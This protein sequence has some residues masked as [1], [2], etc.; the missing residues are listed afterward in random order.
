[1]VLFLLLS[2][3]TSSRH[4]SIFLIHV[5]NSCLTR[6]IIRKEPYECLLNAASVRLHYSKFIDDDK[7]TY[8]YK[9]VTL[10]QWHLRCF[11][12]DIP[13]FLFLFLTVSAA[14]VVQLLQPLT[15]PAPFTL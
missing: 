15:V 3:S 13:D 7:M 9:F 8:S 11:L 1:M 4:K 5:S 14:A 2:C 10:Q 6:I 12:K